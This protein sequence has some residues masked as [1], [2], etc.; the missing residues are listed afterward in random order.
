MSSELVLNNGIHQRRFA[1]YVQREY[2]P[3]RRRIGVGAVCRTSSIECTVLNYALSRKLIMVPDG[4]NLALDFCPPLA[5]YD[6]DDKSPIVFMLHG[7]LGA[8]PFG[9]SH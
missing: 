7:L 3:Y 4:G 2:W 8:F 1:D 9:L 6:K 5:S